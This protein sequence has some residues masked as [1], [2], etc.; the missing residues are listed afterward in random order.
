MSQT[1][2]YLSLGWLCVA[3]ALEYGATLGGD[4]SIVCG[5]ALLIWA[6]PFSV[7]AEFYL[8]DFAL[9]W[10]PRFA[11]QILGGVFEVACAY[12]F[13]F[14]AIPSIWVVRKRFKGPGSNY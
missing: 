8:Y 6:A 10:V 5:W 13:W 7:L 2:R 14:V 9:Q 1:T 12:W 3:I 4:A 11:V